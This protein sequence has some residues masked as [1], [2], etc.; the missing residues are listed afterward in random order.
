MTTNKSFQEWN[1]VFDNS[2]CVVTLVDRL[3]HKAE[4]INIDGESYRLKEAKE[5]SKE[6][7]RRRRAP[8]PKGN[9]EEENELMGRIPAERLRELRNKVDIRELISQHLE[10]PAARKTSTPSIS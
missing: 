4:V 5:R 10:I 3:I 1:E 7:E 9:E 8:P 2:A 6:G